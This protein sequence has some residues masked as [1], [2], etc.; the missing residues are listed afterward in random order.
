M[1]I[2][3]GQFRGRPLAAPGDA[4]TRPTSDKVRE[5]VFNILAHG[6]TGFAIEGCR[7]LDLFAGTGALGLEALSRGAAYCLFVEEGTEARAIIR[8]NVEALSL[9]GVSKIF[10]RDAT[11]LG[12]AGSQAPFG[13]VFLDPPYGKGLAERALTSAAAGGWLVPGAIAVI[14]E[15]KGEPIALPSQFAELDRRRWGDTQVLFARYIGTA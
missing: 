12:P 6:I 11:T 15:R 5:S 14:E 9:T 8:R 7:V 4:T 1:R 13:L 2:V 3:G 10:R